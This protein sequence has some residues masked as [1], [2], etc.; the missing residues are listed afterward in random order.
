[1]LNLSIYKFAK[2]YFF[3]MSRIFSSLALSF[4]L[5]HSDIFL[6][7]CHLL[8]IEII[9]PSDEEFSEEY[10]VLGVPEP[11]VLPVTESTLLTLLH[12]SGFTHLKVNGRS[13]KVLRGD[14]RMS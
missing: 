11:E 14:A 1:M 3:C 2:I 13:C 4:L 12:I 8:F 5:F 9:F 7:I 10:A 6:V